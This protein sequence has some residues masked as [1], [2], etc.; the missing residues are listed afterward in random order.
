MT[1]TPLEDRQ[2]LAK[3]IIGPHHL[4]PP[5]ENIDKGPDGRLID[6]VD[7]NQ[8]LD[9]EHPDDVGGFVFVH[10]DSG[11]SRF[12][13][14]R[15]G[16]E[17]E[18]IVD[19][20]R[21]GLFERCH[22]L[23]DGHVLIIEG[24][25]HGLFLVLVQLTGFDM[26]FEQFGHF[27]L[28][29][30]GPELVPEELVEAEC[31]GFG[32]DVKE[33]ND[34]FHHRDGLFA[35]LEGVPGKDG[36]GD[37]FA[38]DDNEGGGGYEA[39]GAGR[40]VGHEDSEEGVDGDVSQQERA[41]EEVSVLADG[42]DFGRGRGEDGVVAGHDDLE[43]GGVEAHEGQREAGEEGRA[44]HEEDDDDVECDGGDVVH[45]A[46]RWLACDCVAVGVGTRTRTR[47]LQ[48]SDGW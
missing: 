47:T 30:D 46:P 24:A 8:I 33:S 31:H 19:V 14:G 11:I 43:A 45:P 26:Y 28:G 41:E 17:V 12:E 6:G 38:K 29:V 34:D 13:D 23:L 44:Q 40:D 1:M 5:A 42:V 35:D 15:H 27:G 21:K 20:E 48:Q 16:G 39:D 3:I 25:L 18:P 2:D 32:E 4:R 22:D 9:E 10:G 7:E 37:D 36:L